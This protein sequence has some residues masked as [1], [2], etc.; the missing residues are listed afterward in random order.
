MRIRYVSLLTAIILIS[1]TAEKCRQLAGGNMAA[2]RRGRGERFTFL[3]C[4]DMSYGSVACILKE[5]VKVYMYYVRASHVHK[6]RA[7]A[8]KSAL[9]RNLSQGRSRRDAAA[10]AAEVGDA[11]A[12]RA[13]LQAKHVMAPTVSSVWDFFETVYAGGTTCEGMVRSAGTF[14]GAYSGGLAGEGRLRWFGFLIGSQLG[15]WVGGRLGLAVYD[16][17]IGVHY[18]LHLTNYKPTISNH[19]HSN[20]SYSQI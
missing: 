8:T 1:L 7:E 18:L 6:V 4:L 19:I 9:Q 13:Y 3:N 15:S 10:A 20:S 11:A 14:L 17:G 2:G 5:A 16:V 12:R